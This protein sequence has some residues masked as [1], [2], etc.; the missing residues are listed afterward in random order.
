MDAGLIGG[1]V[2]SFLGVIGGLIGTWFSIKNTNSPRE[3]AF[4]VK[5]AIIAWIAITIFLLLLLTLPQPY[6]FLMWIPYGIL[7]PVGINKIN[8]GQAE[9][10]KQESSGETPPEEL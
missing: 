10:R 1:I 4:M 8:K 9:I 6:N 7:L 2:G 3:R 5:M